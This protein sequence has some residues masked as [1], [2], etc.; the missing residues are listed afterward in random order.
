MSQRIFDRYLCMIAIL[1]LLAQPHRTMPCVFLALEA[2]E[3]SKSETKA[4]EEENSSY[5][6]SGV[7]FRNTF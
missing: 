4:V 7:H 6:F 5:R 1:D 3:T 2:E